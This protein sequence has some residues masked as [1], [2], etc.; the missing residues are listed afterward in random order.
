M[1]DLSWLS[2]YYDP[3]HTLGSFDIGS[4]K[5]N[6]D[7]IKQLYQEGKRLEEKLMSA[8]IYGPTS[9][10]RSNLAKILQPSPQSSFNS[11]M[12]SK[13]VR[14]KSDPKECFDFFNG[15]YDTCSTLFSSQ[16]RKAASIKRK[17]KQNKRKEKNQ[18]LTIT[19]Q[20]KKEV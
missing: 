5:H 14:L 15:K 16:F 19:S 11:S 2:R 7:R 13:I 8:I 17:K 6:K 3:E 12:L 9:Q 20:T 18:S 1:K 10:G 4:I